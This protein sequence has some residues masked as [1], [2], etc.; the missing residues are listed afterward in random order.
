MAEVYQIR[1]DFAD[2]IISAD[3]QSKT[4]EHIEK[5]NDFIRSNY[6]KVLC[7]ENELGKSKGDYVSI[8]CHDL[9]DHIVRENMIDAIQ[10][11]LQHMSDNMHIQLQKILVVGLGNRF[12][13]SDALGP[14]AANEILVTAHLYANENP[15]Y[16]KGTRNV[17]VL[18]P[19]VMGQTGLE[20]LSIVQS[21]AQSY[22]PDRS[23]ASPDI[24]LGVE[25][26]DKDAYAVTYHV[27]SRASNVVFYKPFIQASTSVKKETVVHEIGHC[28]G[29][30]HTQSSNNSKSVM[31]KTGFNGKAYPLSDDKSGI[32]VIY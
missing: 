5:K 2:E 25:N 8:E 32:K 31:R 23:A 11:N 4:Y 16:L 24:T 20:S 17:A 27:S 15:K 29:L 19:G 6:I 14:Q 9:G 13:T 1:S 21:V 10:E 18:Q 12:I 28:L 30:A 3:I 7:D 26:V 22:Q